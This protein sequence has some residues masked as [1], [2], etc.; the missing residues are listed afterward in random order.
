MNQLLTN[1]QASPFTKGFHVVKRWAEQLADLTYVLMPDSG[2]G[3]PWTSARQSMNFA[4]V[5]TVM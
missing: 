4:L 3:P 1:I 2:G 5:M